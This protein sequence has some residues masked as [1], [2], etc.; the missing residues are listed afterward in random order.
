MLEYSHPTLAFFADYWP[1]TIFLPTVLL[2]IAVLAAITRM[3][4]QRDAPGRRRPR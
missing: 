2:V 3:W 4:D 1:T